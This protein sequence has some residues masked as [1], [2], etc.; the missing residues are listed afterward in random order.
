[1]TTMKIELHSEQDSERAGKWEIKRK[2]LRLIIYLTLCLINPPAFAQTQ[3]DT[4]DPPPAQ[5]TKP[6]QP[7]RWQ[8]SFSIRTARAFAPKNRTCFKCRARSSRRKSYTRSTTIG[9]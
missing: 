7:S 6:D 1:M 5:D 4:Q 8:W 3:T 2:S 9:G